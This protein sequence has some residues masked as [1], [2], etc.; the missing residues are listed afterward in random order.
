MGSE[1]RRESVSFDA[2]ADALA[3]VDR[4]RLLVAL[5]RLESGIGP[6]G[7]EELGA[8]FDY[9]EHTLEMEHIH[10]PKL[11]EYG[12]VSWDRDLQKI[13]PGPAFG[14]IE[15]IVAVLDSRSEDLPSDWV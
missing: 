6:V 4:R 14:T 9:P 7:L 15:P 5:V 2:V 13:A 8:E 3:D 12:F 1:N 10:L 11:D